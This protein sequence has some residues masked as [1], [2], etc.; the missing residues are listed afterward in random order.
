MVGVFLGTFFKMGISMGF[1]PCKEH[2][3]VGIFSIQ[4]FGTRDLA[5]EELFE[6]VGWLDDFGGSQCEF[7]I[8]IIFNNIENNILIY[9]RF[10]I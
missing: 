1:P 3:D 4:L 8:Y 5:L 6:E 10:C 2:V 9:I 7:N